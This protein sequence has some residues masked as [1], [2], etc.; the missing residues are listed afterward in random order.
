M[1]EV[2][3]VW[4]RWVG[5]WVSGWVGYLTRRGVVAVGGVGVGAAGRVEEG[6]EL[7]REGGWVGGWVEEE[8]KAV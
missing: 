2:L 6:I 7:C 8:E 5:G 3:D 4:G 1:D